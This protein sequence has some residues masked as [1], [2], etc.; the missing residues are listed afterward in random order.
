M[1]LDSGPEVRPKSPAKKARAECPVPIRLPYRLA[2][3]VHQAV[4][5]L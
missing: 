2:Y 1:E 5:V 4:L 3:K